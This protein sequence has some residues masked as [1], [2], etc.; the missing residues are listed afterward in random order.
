MSR[1][2]FPRSSS[3]KPSATPAANKAAVLHPRNRHQQRYDFDAL[4]ATSPELAAFIRLT[5]S[6]NHSIDFTDPVAIKALNRALLQN[7]YQIND[8]DIPDGYLC[9]PI[10]GRADYIHNLA[11]LLA[12]A[13]GGKIPAGK[14]IQAMD[15]GCGANCIYPL[16]GQS[17]YGWRFIAADIDPVSLASAE[18][19]LTANPLQQAAISLR[20]Q[21]DKDC[22]FTHVLQHNEFLD[23]TLCNPP[24]HESPEQMSRGNQRKWKNLG[25]WD[26][27]QES[28]SSE[29][30]PKNQPLNFGG[31]N[32]ELWCE[33]GEVHFISQ[34]MRES[35]QYASQVY[36]FTSLVSRQAALPALK[37]VLR[38]IGVVQQQTITMTQG[39]KSSRFIAWSFLN[40]EQQTIWRQMRWQ[41]TTRR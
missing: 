18:R 22:Y 28:H 1:K 5:P 32:N 16:I 11:D 7:W 33:G 23:L 13:N 14:R 3:H 26:T 31:Q 24:F 21:P 4:T 30:T 40:A 20:Q 34:M 19:V 10:P 41:N 25:K 17:E 9:P 8:W 38:E 29:S 12:A 37:K 39:Q 15:I 2:S 6:G 36:W 27:P 35:Q